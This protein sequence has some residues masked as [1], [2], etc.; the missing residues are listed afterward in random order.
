M[1]RLLCIGAAASILILSGCSGKFKLNREQLADPVEWPYHRGQAESSGALEG[2][3][4]G[5]LTVLW[6]H[7]TSGKPAGPLTLYYGSLVYPSTRKKIEYFDMAS[8]RHEGKLKTSGY[9]QAG[10]V[11]RDSLAF[12]ALATRRNRVQAVN[13]LNQKDLWQRSVKEASAGTILVNNNLIIGSAA[14]GILALDPVD[15]SVRWKSD[16][17]LRAA[18]PSSASHGLVFQPID[19]GQVVA[20]DASSGD[21]RYR[22]T[23]GAQV[24]APVAVTDRAF[25]ADIMGDV[26]AFEPSNGSIVWKSSVAHPIWAAPAVTGSILVVGNSGGQVVGL[27]AA[28]GEIRW[29]F[30]TTK[31]VRAAPLIVDLYVVAANMAGE[32]FVLNRETGDLVDRTALRG[33]VTTSPV[34][35]GRRV[36][37]ATDKGYITCF[38]DT[39][40]HNRRPQDQRI[41]SQNGSERTPALVGARNRDGCQ[42]SRHLRKQSPGR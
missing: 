26:T 41:H 24:T 32:V 37:V 6:E 42:E 1:T 4:N 8:G 39:D 29:R 2:S 25:V 3:F 5:K 21:E 28:T 23:I 13:L 17:K 38:G 7:R 15:G 31:V 20:L 11:I 33:A 40:E 14:G 12:Y 34:S 16:P 18:A 10:M 27:D 22:V 35:D 30:E 19:G 9:T 36:I